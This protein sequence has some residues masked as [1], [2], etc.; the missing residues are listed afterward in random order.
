LKNLFDEQVSA[1]C[2]GSVGN[3]V[4][5][6]GAIYTS[7]TGDFSPSITWFDENFEHAQYVL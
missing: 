6:K 2:R 1:L 7:V 4:A 3:W 5:L